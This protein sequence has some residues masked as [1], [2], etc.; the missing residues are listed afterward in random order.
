MVRQMVIVQFRLIFIGLVIVIGALGGMACAQ[1]VS[2]SN[3]VVPYHSYMYDYWGN[4]VPTPQAYLSSLVIKGESLGIGALKDPSD[5]CV[6]ENGNIYI[7][8]TGND[9]IICLDP[10]W[11]VLQVISTFHNGDTED[12][13][14]G[15]KGVYITSTEKLYVADTTNGRI[16][17]FDADGKYVRIIGPPKSDIDGVL[18]ERFIYRPLR[19]GVDGH[20][21]IYVISQDLPEGF[22]AFSEAGEFR[23]FTGAPRVYPNLADY[24]WRRLA[25]KEQRERMR[26]FLP[27]E[28]SGL[29]LDED[30][31]IYATSI[32]EDSDDYEGGV[33]VKIRKLNPKGEDL[34][35]RLG[36]NPPIGDVEFPDEWS[37]AT[38][39]RSSLMVD[40]TVQDLGVYSMLDA[41]RG[42]VFTYDNNGN[43]LYMFGLMGTEHGQ[44][45][46]P[47]AIASQGKTLMVLDALQGAI[48]VYEPTDYALL[49]WAAMDAYNRGDYALTEQTWRKVLALNSNYDLAYTGIGRTLLRREQYEEA[50]AFFK[51]G[52]NRREYS[53]A[54]EL[55]RKEVIYR[56][57]PRVAR[58]IAALLLVFLIFRYAARHRRLSS[59]SQVAAS[60]AGA[61]VIH[62][63]PK[64]KGLIG[65]TL[66]S[67]RFGLYTTIHPIEGFNR[68]KT[69][70]RGTIS[71]A[72]IVL[73]LVVLTYIFARQYTGFIFNT[74]DLTRLNVIVE[75]LS[76]LVPFI[77]W[78]GI[79]WALTTLMEGKGTFRDI[80][81]ATAFALIPLVLT[82]IPLTVLSNYITQEEGAFYYLLM[83]LGTLWAGVLVVIGAVM[84]T[85]EYDMPKTVFTCICTIA[86][87]GFALFL[88][89]LFI[90][91]SE[92]VILFAREVITELMYRT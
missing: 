6:S 73:V 32:D 2:V 5:L 74:S 26:V 3:F 68:L 52:N 31:F 25:T 41:K 81:I 45:R 78:C 37:G 84:T 43:L 14:K 70:K 75:S 16:V 9:R 87:M 28:Y 60:E 42:R 21:R 10:E 53:D 29:D 4:A 65:Q 77:L 38:Y 13:L 7:A 88:G 18:P 82:V 39:Q 69:E 27:T 15:P 46:K 22:I 55:Y 8:D 34:L 17:H 86:G 64:Q 33:A 58:V 61:E 11:G 19:V 71:A 24:I 80:V 90:S 12:S 76:V 23:G 35:R 89:F 79:N 49:I 48:V 91:L 20:G 66:E 72:L 59:R 1:G 56:E 54:F 92:Q 50:M 30:G 63:L 62:Q 57:F 40:V 83:S 36:F 44:L 67:L 47:V 85:H 51:L